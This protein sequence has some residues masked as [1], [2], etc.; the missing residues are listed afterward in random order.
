MFTEGPAEAQMPTVHGTVILHL[1]H[2]MI[3][4]LLEMLHLYIPPV[5]LY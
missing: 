5:T 2:Y 4:I 1:A 3:S